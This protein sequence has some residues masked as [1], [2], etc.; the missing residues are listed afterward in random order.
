MSSSNFL[1]GIDKETQKIVQPKVNRKRTKANT[2]F[3]VKWMEMD[4]IKHVMNKRVQSKEK[5]LPRVVQKWHAV[6]NICD[7]KSIVIDM[8][9]K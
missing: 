7:T 1:D 4:K 3:K 6:D 5:L 8:N 9:L 2:V